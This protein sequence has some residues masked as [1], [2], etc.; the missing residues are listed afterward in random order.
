MK[1]SIMVAAVLALWLVSNSFAAPVSINLDFNAPVLGTI[2]DTNGLGTGFTTR[3]PGTGSAI[4]PNDPNMNLLAVP[5]KL[6][7]TSTHADIN[8]FPGPTGTNLPN[9]EAPGVFVPA[10]GAGDIFV[11]AVFEN[12][13]LPN[14]SDQL[15]L[16]VG[17]NEN[18]V[19]R[20]GMHE[21]N[22]YVFS[23][24]TG[25]GDQNTFTA[26]GAFTTGDDI[27]ATIS[28]QAGLWALSWN[29]V[30]T[31]TSGALPAF[32]L[33]WLDAQPNLY[34]GVLASNAGTPTSF[35]G[36]INNFS[37]NVVPEP[38][39]FVLAVLGLVGLATWAWRRKR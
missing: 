10:V 6:L 8:Q 3:L 38:S 23:E 9:L 39:T 7:L 26:A 22:V 5:G 15:E 12:V 28:R 17:A 21:T 20:A 34:F 33:P 37:V 27:E 13:H 14:G 31:A 35:I 18:L 4:P 25:S 2:N 29:N 32:S 36:Q 19:L 24:N 30:T 11:S 1:R 16:Y